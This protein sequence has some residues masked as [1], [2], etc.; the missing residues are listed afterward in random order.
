MRCV[1]VPVLVIH[2]YRQDGSCAFSDDIVE[3]KNK[4]LGRQFLDKFDSIYV[5]VYFTFF[6]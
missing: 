4:T 1:D 3:N 5:I 2:C 6:M